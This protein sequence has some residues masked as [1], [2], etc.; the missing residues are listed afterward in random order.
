MP[1]ATKVGRVSGRASFAAFRTS[2]RRGR[3]GVVGVVYLPVAPGEP[4]GVRAAFAVGRRVGT[5]VE[6]NRVKRRL[7]AIVTGQAPNLLPGSYLVRA[8]PGA[9]SVAF[10]ELDEMMRQAFV[11]T[12]TWRSGALG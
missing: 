5:A 7:R 12:G 1:D 3:R 10:E 11:R 6:R 8:F 4:E 2:D 9:Q